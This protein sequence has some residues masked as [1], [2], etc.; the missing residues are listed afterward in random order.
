MAAMW[1][2]IWCVLPLCSESS[3]SVVGLSPPRRSSDGVGGAGG[4]PGG[5]HRHLRRRPGRATDGCLDLTPLIGHL[6]RHEGQVA[7]LHRPRRQLVDQRA[8]GLLGPGHG[9]QARG[10]LVEAVHDPGPVGR[11]HPRRDQLG[12]VREAGEEAPDQGP[13]DV[14]GPGVHHESGRLVHHRHR[15]VGV[16][17][18]EADAGLRCHSPVSG[19]RQHDRERGALAEH[20]PPHPDGRAIDQHPAGG[21]Q[22]GG[23]GPGDVGHHGHA[24]I[25]PD[26][27]QERRDL[28]RDG[29]PRA[30]RTVAPAPA[31]PPSPSP[32]S[33][34]TRP[35]RPRT[36][37]RT[38]HRR[39]GPR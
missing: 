6:T 14:A 8:V 22:L 33:P 32:A 24:P 2:R 37:P 35:P 34:F 31:S 17:D 4:L 25:H 38:V 19:R 13:L 1:T 29:F 10:P 21:D 7:A 36:P 20:D 30:R 3:S 9:E 28:R 26:A 27:R 16:D 18:L 12:Q 5:R 39:E 11:T 15:L 23:G